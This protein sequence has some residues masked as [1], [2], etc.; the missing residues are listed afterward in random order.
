MNIFLKNNKIHLYLIVLLKMK[1]NQKTRLN[2]CR[3]QSS[4][5][6]LS[7]KI[8]YTNILDLLLTWHMVILIHELY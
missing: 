8:I 4:T 6:Y 5:P 2:P 1:R 7:F 3:Q